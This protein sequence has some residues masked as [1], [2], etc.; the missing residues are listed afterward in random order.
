MKTVSLSSL[1]V[2]PLSLVLAPAAQTPIQ[3]EWKPFS[4]KDGAF[5]ILFPGTPTEHKKS[6]SA[7]GGPLEVLYYELELPGDDGK[8]LVG[9]SEV[10]A[11]SIKAG[12]EDKRLDKARDGA[13]SSTK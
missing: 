3:G 12:T 1:F 8:F 4:P 2:L 13:L 9:Y 5:T 6:V 7:P 10:P 11:S